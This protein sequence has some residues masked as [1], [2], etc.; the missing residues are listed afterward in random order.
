MFLPFI[1]AILLL[2]SFTQANEN[3]LPTKEQLFQAVI[4]N[5]LEEVRRLLD[6]GVDPNSTNDRSGQTPLFFVSSVRIAEELRK[7]GADVNF[8]S[9]QGVKSFPLHHVRSEEL[10]QWFVNAGADI[11][12][13]DEFENTPL[14]WSRSP[15]LTRT[16]INAGADVN[17]LNHI[18]RTPLYYAKSVEDAIALLEAGADPSVTDSRGVTPIQ[19]NSLLREAMRVLELRKKQAELEKE[20]ASQEAEEVAQN[21][22]ESFKHLFPCEYTK[23]NGYESLKVK[24][25][26]CGQRHTCIAEVSCTFQMGVAPNVIQINRTFQAICSTLADGQCPKA[27][28]CVLDRSV[29]AEEESPTTLPEEEPASP[30]PSSQPSSSPQPTGATR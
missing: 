12:A 29:V 4:S 2:G 13:R 25:A 3:E 24:N 9:K 10:I 21:Q 19:E 23:N 17:A 27:N 6:A 5:N 22:K 14:F 26:V 8:Q 20:R 30:T 11:E 16:F 15:S 1:F 7:M 28:D 18:Q